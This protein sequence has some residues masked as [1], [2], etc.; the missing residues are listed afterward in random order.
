M[1]SSSVP[2]SNSKNKNDDSTEKEES[3]DFNDIMKGI[4]LTE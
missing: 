2:K 1:L 4:P 3:N